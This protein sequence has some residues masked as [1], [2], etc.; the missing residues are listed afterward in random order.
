[1]SGITEE[2]TNGNNPLSNFL[3]EYDL[4]PQLRSNQERVTEA[5]SEVGGSALDF[6]RFV[7]SSLIATLTVLVLTFF[8][9]IE[10]PKW[11]SLIKENVSPQKLAHREKLAGYMY[12]AVTGYVNGNLLTS[13]IAAV[14][15]SIFLSIIGVPYSIPLGILLGLFDL[16]PLVGATIGSAILI[17]VSL[18]VSVPTAIAVTIFCIVYQQFE[19][20]ILQPLVYAKT[21]DISPL[22]V[23]VAALVGASLGGIMG[24]LVA[25]PIAA[26]LLILLKDYLQNHRAK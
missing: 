12:E 6:V 18:F 10:G 5:V 4:V 9:L 17:L 25:I 7:L 24:A 22:T 8:M 19:N 26:S 21:V 15:T 13:L 20:N 16:L 1:M 3:R 23:M 11:V 2:L 14:V